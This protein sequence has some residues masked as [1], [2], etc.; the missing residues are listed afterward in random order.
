[1]ATLDQRVGKLSAEDQRH[2]AAEVERLEARQAQIA[3]RNEKVAAL[4]K[5]VGQDAVVPLIAEYLDTIAANGVDQFIA[6]A[7][8]HTPTATE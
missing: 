5:E 1:M 4:V 8:E 7:G 3:A 2:V 6:W